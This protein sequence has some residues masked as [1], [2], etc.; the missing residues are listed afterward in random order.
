MK[1]REFATA[2]D[3]RDHLVQMRAESGKSQTWLSQ[4]MGTLQGYVSTFE[5]GH[6][7]KEPFLS[8]LR[9]YAA[10]LGA[11]VTVVVTEPE[12]RDTSGAAS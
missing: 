5:S 11:E 1:S 12:E 8:S 7:S 3:A 10:A 2:E 4:K 6:R 9:K